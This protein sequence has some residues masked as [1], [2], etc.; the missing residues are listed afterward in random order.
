MGAGQASLCGYPQSDQAAVVIPDRTATTHSSRSSSY[1]ARVGPHNQPPVDTSSA[2][3]SSCTT[4]AD[5]AGPEVGGVGGMAISLGPGSDSGRLVGD[6]R[7]DPDLATRQALLLE[8]PVH[9]L[10]RGRGDREL[11]RQLHD[12]GQLRPSRVGAVSDAAG[13]DRRD[14]PPDGPSPVKINAHAIDRR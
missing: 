1:R 13:D 3:I 6:E 14:L 9:L 2:R 4:S 7:P 8:M 5:R 11:R 10:H 12:R